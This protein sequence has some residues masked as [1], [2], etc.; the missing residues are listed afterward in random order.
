MVELKAQRED[1]GQ[2]E[3]DERLGIVEELE[4]GGFIVEVNGN[5]AVLSSRF[6]GLGHVA[7]PCGWQSVWMRHGEVNALKDQADGERIRTP[8]LNSGESGVRVWAWRGGA[9]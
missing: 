3:L 6:G 7:S 2:D 9:R 5:G 4:V 8:P 1:E